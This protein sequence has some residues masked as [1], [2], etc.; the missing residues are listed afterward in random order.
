MSATSPFWISN[1]GTGTSTLYNVDP[2]TQNTTK[3][4]L[5]VAIPGAGDVTG[6]VFNG[7]ADFNGDRF[8]FVSEDGTISGWRGALGTNAEVLATALPNNVFKGAALGTISANSYVYAANF[9]AGR[10]D[11]LKGN[12]G[13]PDLA[14]SFLDPVLP[15]GYAPF[16][17]Q[18]L[19]DT[20]FVT[21]AQQDASGRD[22]VAGAGLGI[23]DRFDLNGAFLGR[24]AT[25]GSLDAPWG[26]AIAPASYG[27]LAGAL[28]VGNAGDGRITAFDLTTNAMLG[29]LLDDVGAALSIDGLWALT[30][31]NGVSGGSTDRVYFTAGPDD[32]DHGLFG[33]L[34]VRP[35]TDGP[36][37]GVPE[38]SSIALILAGSAGIT[39][40]RRRRAISGAGG[41]GDP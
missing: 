1:N 15:A 35:G 22:E 20:L 6:Q 17:I 41:V 2:L 13:A 14:G 7:G 26:L 24:V 18:N 40:A 5:T 32:E 34:S 39:R 11:V 28:L 9:Y 31:G 10:I 33:V 36:S 23:V 30:T 8:L 27:S 21:Y 4:A 38:P 19:G 37:P 16:N 25:G 12:P 29:Q 3:V